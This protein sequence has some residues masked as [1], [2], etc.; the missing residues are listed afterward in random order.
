MSRP[1]K[2]EAALSHDALQTFIDELKAQTSRPTLAQVQAHAKAHGIEVSLMGAKTFRDRTFE[3]HLRGIRHGREK[4]K[5]IIEAINGEGAPALDAAEELLASEI[6]DACTKPDADLA[7]IAKT[8]VQLRSSIEQRN[9][10][11][12]ADADLKRKIAD[13]EAA[14]A[15]DARRLEV[16][17]QRLAL[18]Q[19][20]AAKAA[21]DHA[22]EIR[23][24]S[25]DDRL[26]QTEK[27]ERVRARLFG[28]QPA[29]FKPVAQ[30]GEQP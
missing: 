11:T 17:E 19:F 24:I 28:A 21:L 14:R 7:A 23:A 13:S 20:D 16:L 6:L 3:D 8:A 2:I 15:N 5:Q 25:A 30:K 1:N 4:A 9:D 22:K 27:V 10:R 29:D 18:V 26:A 12:R